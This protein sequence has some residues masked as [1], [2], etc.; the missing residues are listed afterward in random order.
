[1]ARKRRSKKGGSRLSENQVLHL[2]LGFCFNSFEGRA[3]DFPFRDEAH[4]RQLWNENRDRLINK[5]VGDGGGPVRREPGTRPA[6]FWAFDAPEPRRII[7]N[8]EYWQPPPGKENDWRRYWGMHPILHPVDNWEEAGYP[9][10]EYE[11]EASYLRRLKLLL[12]GEAEALE[13]INGE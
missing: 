5:D 10:P 13:K 1:M 6:A 12:P 2:L 7:Q 3:L 11:T 4:Q 8:A 9:L